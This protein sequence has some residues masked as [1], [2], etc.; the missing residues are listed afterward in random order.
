ME[1]LLR[2]NVSPGLE[3]DL[4]DF[5]L[6]SKDI[7]GFQSIPVRGHGQV[8]AMSTAEQV[9]GRRYRV[10]FEVVLDEES[11]ESLLRRLK[12]TFPVHDAI[13]WVSPVIQSGRLA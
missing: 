7:K 10:Q 6:G 13:Y 8:G 2:L 5:L 9:A 1:Y 4:V 11:L 3:E 12:E